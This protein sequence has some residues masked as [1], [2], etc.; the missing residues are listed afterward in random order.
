MMR[1]LS[2]CRVGALLLM[3][4]LSVV[5]RQAAAQITSGSVTGSIRDSQGGVI[6]GAS[7][8]LVSAARGTSL[9]V[10]SNEEGDFA[11]PIVDAETYVLRVGLAGFKTLTRPGIIVHAGDRLSLGVVT[12]SRGDRRDRHRPRRLSPA[13]TED[14]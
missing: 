13:P 8:T 1:Q 2:P 10:T 5:P 14:R 3:L 9:D 4:A 12:I 11:F 7:V 6:P